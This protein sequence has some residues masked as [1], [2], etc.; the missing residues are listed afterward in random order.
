MPALDLVERIAD[1]LQEVGVGGDDRAVEMELDYRL[2]AIDRRDRL[3]QFGDAGGVVVASPTE[4]EVRH[5]VASC[6]RFRRKTVVRRR[7]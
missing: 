6:N 5:V 1:G 7:R 3:V 4:G 2:R